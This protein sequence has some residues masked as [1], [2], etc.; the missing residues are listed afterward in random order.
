M[1]ANCPLTKRRGCS[2]G[3]LPG[4]A[5]TGQT[6]GDLHETQYSSGLPSR[7][8]AL[9]LR[10]HVPDS[11]H[12]QGRFAARRNLFELPSLLHRQAKAA[13]YGRPRRAFHKEVREGSRGAKSDQGSQQEEV[14]LTTAPFATH[15]SRGGVKCR[16]THGP[17]PD[18]FSADGQRAIRS[19]RAAHHTAK[20]LRASVLQLRT[21]EPAVRAPYARAC[22]SAA[23]IAR[24]R[25]GRARDLRTR[26]RARLGILSRA[27][28]AAAG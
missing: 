28:R 26:C 27:D 2:S 13:G 15:A 12:D 5:Q 7:N 23:R 10:A 18:D 24:I 21:A 25:R 16:A 14:A 8:G 20:S 22:L 6:A 17:A 4:T 1:I 3:A 11:L 19:R 9:R